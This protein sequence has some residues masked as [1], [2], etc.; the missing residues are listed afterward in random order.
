MTPDLAFTLTQ[1]ISTFDRKASERAARSKRGYHN[2]FALAQY[3]TRCDEVVADVDAG[4]SPRAA[5][6]AAFEGRLR[7][8][9]LKAIGEPKATPD[10]ERAEESRPWTQ[11]YTPVS[12]R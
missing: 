4:A 1:A 5:I 9:C 2:R 7:D 12:A 3:L 11:G 10:E 6:I 8:V